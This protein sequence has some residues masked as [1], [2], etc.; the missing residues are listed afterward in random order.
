MKPKP[1]RRVPPANGKDLRPNAT[2][3][4]RVAN[5]G[6]DEICAQIL[7]GT[8]LT[9]IAKSAN[10]TFGKLQAYLDSNPTFS[11]RAR[12]ARIKTAKFWDDQA[13]ARIDNAK[14]KFELD[15]AREL[16]HHYRWRAAMISPRE[17]GN[18]TIIAGDAENPLE[19]NIS[20]MITSA[21]DL[22]KKIRGPQD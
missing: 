19:V 4:R 2:A 12:D 5:I 9:D 3:Q 7:N 22:L 16:A 21:D 11:A 20:K 10:T 14:D 13:T 18:K 6:I 8:T 15:K 1:K 17:Y